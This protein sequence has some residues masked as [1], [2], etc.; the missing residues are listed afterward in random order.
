MSPALP[1]RRA[2]PTIALSI[3]VAVAALACGSPP[4]DSLP[5]GSNVPTETL[6][7]ERDAYPCSLADVAPEV[8]ERSRSLGKE[9]SARLAEGASVA[10]AA[11]WLDGQASVVVVEHDEQ[12]LRFRLDGGRFVWVMTEELPKPANAHD[13]GTPVA[14]GLL[15]PGQ[16][17]SFSAPRPRTAERP[18]SVDAVVGHGIPLKSAIVLAPFAFAAAWIPPGGA[19][20]AA[21]ILEGARGYQHRVTYLENATID[22]GTVSVDSFTELDSYDVVFIRSVGGNICPEGEGCHSFV[23]AEAVDPEWHM[24]DAQ[25]ASLDIVIYRGAPGM[26]VLAVTTDFFRGLYPGGLQHKIIMFDVPKLDEELARAVK[27]S[28]SE[29]YFWNAARPDHAAV[30]IEAYLRDLARTGRSPAVVYHE[31]AGQLMTPTATFVGVKPAAEGANRV[32]EVVWI[33]DPEDPERELLPGDQI[34]VD[35]R[36]GDGEPDKVSW[37]VDIDGLTEQEAAATRLTMLINDTEGPST[38]AASGEH[39][40]DHLWRL[41]GSIEV[42]DLQLGDKLDILAIA[43]LAEKGASQW[44]VQVGVDDRLGT[45]WEGVGTATATTLWDGVTLTRSAQVTFLRETEE[46]AGSTKVKFR[47]IEGTVT[48]SMAGADSKGCSHTAGPIV[49]PVAVDSA[50]LTF[51]ISRLAEGIITYEG[52]GSV[53]DGPNVELLLSCPDFSNVTLTGAEG[54]WFHAP[55]DQDWFLEGTEIVGTWNNGAAIGSTFTWNFKKVK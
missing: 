37:V 13:L 48:W 52:Q 9:A 8:L 16:E 14:R 11:G 17:R 34:A 33:R 22:A 5:A 29:Y 43:E 23:G 21:Q 50:Y 47:P 51:D 35:G 28:T 38:F 4:A 1:R 18:S 44:N 3:T 6:D 36:L 10:E 24:T 12:A 20:E 2:I 41:E 7:C 26:D 27:G 55:G 40:D 53:S 49:L 19:T 45:V 30:A 42:P 25:A 46:R 32:R 15:M 31:M 54:T 39:I